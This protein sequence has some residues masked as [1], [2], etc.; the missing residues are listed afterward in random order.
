VVIKKRYDMGLE[1]V[2]FDIKKIEECLEKLIDQELKRLL[3]NYLINIEQILGSLAVPLFLMSHG[4]KSVRYFQY[5]LQGAIATK[6]VGKEKSEKGKAEIEEYIQSKFK[7]EKEIHAVDAKKEIEKLRVEAPFLDNAFKKEE[8][9]T[10]VNSWTMFEATIKDLWIYCLNTH[11]NIFLFNVLKSDTQDIEG[12]TGK[13]ISIGLLAKYNFDISKK[14]G[15]ILVAK[16][17]FTTVNGIKKSY[18]DL[19]N[20]KDSELSV[21]DDENLL[22]LEI[23]RHLIVHNAGKIDSDYLKRTTRKDEKLGDRVL[24]TEQQLCDYCNSNIYAIIKFFE[25][26][27]KKINNRQRL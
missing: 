15:E 18:K 21:F 19:F 16:Y 27:D 1:S 22:Q 9:N 4:L 20:M 7:Q 8:L 25:M 24:L 23:M 17:D 11:P 5:W 12:I 13:N 3:G 10:I 26:A 2:G 14:L 6:N